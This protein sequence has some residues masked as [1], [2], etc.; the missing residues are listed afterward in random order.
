MALKRVHVVVEGRV[1]GVFFRA[2][3]RDEAVRLGLTGWVRN[4]ADGAVEAV[5]EGQPESVTAMLQWLEVGSPLSLVSGVKVT[6]E[7]PVGDQ[8]G[9]E[10]KYC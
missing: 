4:R 6:A 9:F 7:S 5:F 1:Q 8:H 10:I 2:Y 3:T